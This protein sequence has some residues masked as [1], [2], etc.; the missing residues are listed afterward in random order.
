M[1]RLSIRA[2]VIALLLFGVAMV[3]TVIVVYVASAFERNTRTMTKESLDSARGA[4]D[5][6]LKED[7]EKL[8]VATEILFDSKARMQAFADRDRTR[9][10]ADSKAL[11]AMLTE[12]YGVTHMNYLW[13]DG[14]MFLRMTKPGLF[15]DVVHRF[16]ITEVVRT[17]KMVVGLEQG[18]TGFVL[19]VLRPVG[20]PAGSV[21]FVETGEEITSFSKRLKL[22]TG[23]DLGFLLLKKHIDPEY[24]A[25]TRGSQG[26]RNNWNDRQDSLVAQSTTDDETLFE[27]GGEIEALP[28]EGLVLDR[29][30]AGDKVL[31]RGIFPVRDVTGSIVGGMFVLR[32]ITTLDA[33]VTSA[34]RGSIAITIVLALLLAGALGYLLE[35]S[36]FGRLTVV[37][38]RLE[39]LSLRVA[40]GDFDIQN[41]LSGK[42]QADEIGRLEQFLSQFLVLIGGTL[43]S[44]FDAEKRVADD[45]KELQSNIKDLLR[46][47]SDASDGNL[48]VR[49]PVTVGALGNVADAFN[50]L[51]ESLQKL[52]GEI[53]SQQTRT[54]A[55]VSNIRSAAQTMAQGATQQASELVSATELVERMN[56]EF[57]QV[58]NNAQNAALS[59]QRTEASAVEGVKAVGKIVTGMEQLRSNVQAGAKKV[60]ALGERSME[61][62]SIVSAINRVSEQTNMLALNAAIEAARAGEHGRGFSV[63]AEEVRK[64]AERTAA[65]T[66]EIDKLVKSIQSETNETV[67]AIEVQT[68]VVERES[69]MV[70]QAGSSLGNIRQASTQSAGLVTEISTVAKQ[71]L[72]STRTVVK[73]MEQISVIAQKTQHEAQSTA[74]NVAE[75]VKANDSLAGSI[76]RFKLS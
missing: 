44:L 41:A 59:S 52:V 19:R 74:I 62:T 58:S 4:F 56:T 43:K 24:W 8:R 47:V 46:V 67:S 60:K 9:L 11:H 34:R 66:L 31:M 65:A 13:P 16:S 27:Y 12:E 37:V 10:F 23:F 39:E 29:I 73:V 72:E 57:E 7:A 38:G 28:S 68:E 54:N 63:V 48:T 42:T 33:A 75:L 51:L 15:D 49:A 40:G 1:E 35:R 22:K 64:L 45:N 3:A 61:I 53:L 5:N 21:G 36:V 2:R 50:S 55:V 14:R 30:K 70:S 18:K 71:Q 6:M 25:M 76:R 32:D 17:K 69:S 20:E 26:L